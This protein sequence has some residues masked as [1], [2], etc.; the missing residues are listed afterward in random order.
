M[1]AVERR[2]AKYRALGEKRGIDWRKCRYPDRS[3]FGESRYPLHEG[4]RFTEQP[5]VYGRLI[6]TS[7]KDSRD[8]TGYY[9]DNLCFGVRLFGVEEVPCGRRGKLIIPVTW[10]NDSDTATYHFDDSTLVKDSEEV[11][12]EARDLFRRANRIAELEA[13]EER[14]EDAKYQAEQQIEDA[15]EEIQALKVTFRELNQE[16]R[17]N[18]GVE[19]PA[20]CA[21]V[22]HRLRA[23]IADIRGLREKIE[24]LTNNYW[25]A[26]Y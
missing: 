26:V 25:E 20:I 1:N 6:L 13:E 22:N 23:C 21:A 16:R 18:R 8:C 19:S 4:K 2:L 24:R 11:E 5:E 3:K 9:T 7:D 14:E 15:K 12:E 10:S 17:W